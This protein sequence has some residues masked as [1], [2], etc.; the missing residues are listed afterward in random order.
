MRE[1]S[2]QKAILDL[3]K[4]RGGYAVK[5][6]QASKAG[7][8]DIIACYKGRFI[9]IEVKTPKTKNNVSELQWHNIELIGNSG[10]KAIVAW[11]ISGVEKFLKGLDETISTSN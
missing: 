4:A 2:I 1:A 10:G 9:A 5:V 6:I 8:P 11:D 3:L 7:V